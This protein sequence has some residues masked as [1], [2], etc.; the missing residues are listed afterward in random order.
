[1]ARPVKPPTEQLTYRGNFRLTEAEGQQ[2]EQAAAD[3]G[4]TVSDYV[5]GL[6]LKSKPRL[7]KA[8]PERVALIKALG[9][10]GNIRADINQVLKDR[11]AHTFV[12]PER[13]EN[14]FVAIENIA[15]K[16]HDELEQ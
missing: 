9:A 6:A 1:M 12:E 3:A 14:V 2:L 10:L 4:V 7:K 8:T 11:F 15:Y 5:R 16:I 13:L